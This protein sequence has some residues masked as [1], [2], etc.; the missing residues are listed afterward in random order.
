[1]AYLIYGTIQFLQACQFIVVL[2][3]ALSKQHLS[4]WHKNLKTT[5][6]VNPLYNNMSFH[7]IHM[8][9]RQL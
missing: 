9:V 4:L 8:H 3:T 2:V 5:S 6:W 1:M 7:R